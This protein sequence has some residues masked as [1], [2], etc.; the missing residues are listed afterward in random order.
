MKNEK[1]N[2]DHVRAALRVREKQIKEL[3]DAIELN[4]ASMDVV[5]DQI[6]HIEMGLRNIR[7][8]A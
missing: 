2:P 4:D 1:L 3:L 6:R 7:R 5:V 8:A